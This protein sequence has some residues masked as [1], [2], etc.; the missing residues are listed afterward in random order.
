M[1]EN[2]SLA[3]ALKK[4][5]NTKSLSLN[6]AAKISGLPQS[7]I[8]NYETRKYT[9][10]PENIKLLARALNVDRIDILDMAE[11]DKKIRNETK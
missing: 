2:I 10:K 8:S 3:V 1:K 4:W 5:R 11:Y 6:D 9:P 7:T